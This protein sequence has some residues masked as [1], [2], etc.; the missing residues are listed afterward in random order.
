SAYYQHTKNLIKR[1]RIF[2][3][4]GTSFRQPRNLNS[5]TTYGL[6]LTGRAQILPIWEATA[7]FNLFHNL[8]DGENIAAQVN[9][10]GFSWF[11]KA[12]TSI[13]LPRQFSLQ[14]NGT[15]EAPKV[16]LQSTTQSVWWIDV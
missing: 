11:G 5:G 8:I 2:Y 13:R 16:S 1:Y 6:E 15:Y 10:S 4:N 9:N 12:N 14:L 7:N 3:E